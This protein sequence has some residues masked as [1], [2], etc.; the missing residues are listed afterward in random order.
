VPP[1]ALPDR[2]QLPPLNVLAQYPAIEMFRWC[3]QAI[4]PTFALTNA[5]APAV[6]EICH[7]LDGLPLAIELAAARSTLFTPQALLA[8]L[9]SRLKLLTSGARDLPSRQQ[10][11][12]STIEWSY[13][14]L[15][16]VEQ[17][18]FRRLAVFVG[19]WTVEAAEVV[20]NAMRDLP[21]NVLD[22]LASLVDQSLVAH[23]AGSDDEPRFMMLET[24]REF[25]LE[26][27]AASG[28]AATIRQRHAAYYLAL[29]EQAEPETCGPQQVRWLAR[30]AVD[31]DNFRATLTWSLTADDGAEFGLRLTDALLRFW[32]VRKHISEARE[33]FE[34]LLAHS[35]G[36]ATTHR[37]AGLLG[38]GDLAFAQGDFARAEALAEAALALSRELG[39]NRGI[40][41]A[42]G[43]LLG[44]AFPRGDYP[45][46][47]RLGEESVALFR[48]AG[49]AR[50]LAQSLEG[51]CFTARYQGDYAR[52]TKYAEEALALDR[53]AEDHFRAAYMHIHLGTLAWIQGD[54]DE[55]V[56][57][58]TESL[59]WFQELGDKINV[60]W[61]LVCMGNVALDQGNHARA[62]ACYQEC[63]GYF[64]EADD[65][66]GIAAYLQGMAGVIGARGHAVQA[67]RLFGAA[68]ICRG[69]GH[70]P[71][72]HERV[73]YERQF[74]AAR[75]QLDE[76]TFTAAW[77]AGQALTLD[78]AIAA[79][80]GNGDRAAG[81]S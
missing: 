65:A 77:A 38:A 35:H 27:L 62:A 44:A 70:Q 80:L 69:L 61:A 21:R 30:L 64:R 2:T 13:N 41:R 48:A 72:P 54:Y 9:S 55:A 75:A 19:G 5:N 47:R 50:G 79:A 52:A 43:G 17:T 31:H 46:A 25:A 68:A 29:A 60:A 15:D 8:R 56:V 42:L 6:A 59:R 12:Q 74:A 7:R 37:V 4:Q 76:A 22:I 18:L 73:R 45:T 3:A 71:A 34:A 40:A 28:E 20:G 10:T 53:E 49:D 63:L 57:H 1:L 67:V 16:D 58:Y 11:L 78:Q 36:A 23:V 33:W 32:W 51:L 24:I 14:L 26:R 81:S 66:G 39:D